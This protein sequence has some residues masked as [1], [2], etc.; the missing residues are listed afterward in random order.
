MTMGIKNGH[1]H[2]WAEKRPACEVGPAQHTKLS[3]RRLS[4]QHRRQRLQV[5][6]HFIAHSQ[7][8]NNKC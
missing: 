7:S 5:Q 3:S 6:R 4:V 8:A 1:A 2:A